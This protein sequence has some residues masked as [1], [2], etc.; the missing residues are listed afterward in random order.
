MGVQVT[1]DD[2]IFYLQRRGGISRYFA[3]L[4][5]Q[6]NSQDALGVEAELATTRTDNEMLLSTLHERNFKPIRRTTRGIRRI[7]SK[8]GVLNDALITWQ[9]EA[10]DQ[11]VGSIL[12]ATYWAPRKSDLRRHQHLAVTVMDLIPELMGSASY[13]GRHGNRGELLKRASVIFT[14][15][16]TTRNLLQE[17]FPSIDSPIITTHLGVNLQVFTPIGKGEEK[18]PFPYILF[19]GKRDGYKRFDIAVKAAAILRNQGFDV[20]LIAVGASP[21]LLESRFME[22]HLPHDRFDFQKA[23]DTQLGMLYRN[24][25]LF[26]FPSNIEGFGLPILEAMASGCPAVLSDIPIFREVAEESAL[27]ATANDPDSFSA[28]MVRILNDGAQKQLLVGLGLDRVRG[29]S[30]AKTAELTANGYRLV[31]QND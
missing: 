26:I 5:E 18:V 30:W 15:S 20:G 9:S 23:N 1:F 24:A 31:T 22:A 16:E 14:I 17:L 27:Y 2:E 12:H 13:L 25:E 6:F 21:T 28:Q 8:S 11:S 19:V 29:F 10:L 7:T 4:I 3:S